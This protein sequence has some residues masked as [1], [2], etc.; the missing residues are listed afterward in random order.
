MGRSSNASAFLF[1]GASAFEA[2]EPWNLTVLLA[3]LM[4]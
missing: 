4:N 2:P 1:W 3:S